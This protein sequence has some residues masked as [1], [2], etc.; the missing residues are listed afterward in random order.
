MQAWGWGIIGVLLALLGLGVPVGYGIKILLS[1][2]KTLLESVKSLIESVQKTVINVNQTV[3]RMAE[4]IDRSDQ[5]H[6]DI[7]RDID[8]GFD[9]VVDKV[10]NES[11]R[12]VDAV[13]K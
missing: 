5:Q 9:R 2:I 4:F 6:S 11:N 13:R 8:T 7:L 3:N 12:I 1:E 10:N